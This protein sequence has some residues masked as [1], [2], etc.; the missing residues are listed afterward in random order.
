M[1]DGL[2][3]RLSR[4]NCLQT[5]HDDLGWI[6]GIHLKCLHMQQQLMRKET[7]LER[8]KRDTWE[9]WEG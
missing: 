4:Q 3:K 9:S 8:I 6:T 7:E 1:E 2:R 5:N